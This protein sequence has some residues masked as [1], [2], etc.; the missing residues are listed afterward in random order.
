MDAKEMFLIVAIPINIML[1]L[2][3]IRTLI[4][5]HKEGKLTESEFSIKIV[6]AILL[7]VIG[8]AVSKLS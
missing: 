7:P 6:L 4:K 8:F 1:A 5:K 3:A 2:L